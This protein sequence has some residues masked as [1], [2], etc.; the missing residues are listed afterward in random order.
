[1]AD[2]DLLYPAPPWRSPRSEFIQLWHGCMEADRPRIEKGID[3]NKCRPSTDFGRGFYMTTLESQ[4]Q[5]WSWLRRETLH[6]RDR[7]IVLRFRIPRSTMGSLVSLSFVRADYDSEDF[8]S[9]VQHCRRSK[10]G[11][12]ATVNNHAGPHEGWYDV[13]SGPVSAM[14]RQR[15]AMQG[16]DQISFHT[17]AAIDL[18]NEA[19]SSND[20]SRYD[21]FNVASSK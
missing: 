11:R 16:A 4:S 3:L 20:R 5:Y 10:K 9:L 21:W 17:Q 14:W 19:M 2:L 7:P 15:V 18:L 6:R 1:M 12:V 13:V 8:W